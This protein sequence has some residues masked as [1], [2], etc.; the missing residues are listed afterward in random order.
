MASLTTLPHGLLAHILGRL[1]SKIGMGPIACVSRVLLN[2]VELWAQER[3][4]QWE[5][6]ATPCFR[7]G[8]VELGCKSVAIKK[9]APWAWFPFA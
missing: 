9:I 5:R 1:H 3:L 4:Q 8:R 7:P 2:E 6:R